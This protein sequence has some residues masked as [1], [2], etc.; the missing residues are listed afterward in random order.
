MPKEIRLNFDDFKIK[1]AEYTGTSPDTIT[2]ET[3]LY[4]DLGM[5]SLGLFSLGMYLIR[6]FGIT[7]SIASV[8]RIQTVNDIYTIMKEEGY[9]SE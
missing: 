2:S 1:V 5:D 8:A 7:I 4:T 9:P 3:N 6:M